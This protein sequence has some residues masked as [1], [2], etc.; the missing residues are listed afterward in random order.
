M[1]VG[2]KYDEELKAK[3]FV[4][5]GDERYTRSTIT[6]LDVATTASNRSYLAV[7]LTARVRRH[8][9]QSSVAFYDGDTTIGVVT[10]NSN[11]SS[12][13][14]NV[15]LDYGYHKFH[16]KYMGNAQCLSS[17]SGIKEIEIVEPDLLK[18]TIDMLLLEES[19]LASESFTLN[20]QLFGINENNVAGL[21]GKT[22]TLIL[23]NET[24]ATA[25]TVSNGEFTFNIAANTLEEGTYY[26]T[27]SFDG[28]NNYLGYDEDFI[29]IISHD[30]C[31]ITAVPKY[32]KIGVGDTAI[33]TV[34]AKSF[35]EE[36]LEDEI[37]KLDGG[38]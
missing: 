11:Q 28:D 15:R 31:S 18:S 14:L 12:V 22:V 23:N 29:F 21:S 5:R 9:G 17:K 27:I 4:I 38:N 7:T 25:T 8:V 30:N 33:F 34:T 1:I 20:G 24:T 26:A 10:C 35:K 19:Y 3:V 2:T 13:S 6:T 36:P 32:S 37:I 16:A